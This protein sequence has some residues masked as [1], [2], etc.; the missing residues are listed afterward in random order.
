MVLMVADT[1]TE[2]KVDEK[3]KL[4]LLEAEVTEELEEQLELVADE[5]EV[6]EELITL[7]TALIITDELEVLEVTV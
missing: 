6:V 7:I 5:V 2:V 3:D 1:E 4:E